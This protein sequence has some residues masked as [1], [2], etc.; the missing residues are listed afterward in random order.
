V[1]KDKH[2]TMYLIDPKTLASALA[3]DH[4]KRAIASLTKKDGP[5]DAAEANFNTSMERYTAEFD[6]ASHRYCF[7]STPQEPSMVVHRVYNAG[8]PRISREKLLERG[9]DPAIIDEA[10]SH[11]A[12]AHW[13]MEELPPEQP[14]K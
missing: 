14:S 5:K 1:V 4:I 9:V 10:T 3:L 6:P 8:A 13:R 7:S 11:T 2:P 12:S